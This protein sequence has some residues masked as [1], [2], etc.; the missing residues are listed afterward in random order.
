MC[1]PVRGYRE[2][3]S[4]NLNVTVESAPL[5]RSVSADIYSWAADRVLRVTP[6]LEGK[7]EGY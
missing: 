6:V 4:G 7:W 1:S 2:V 3:D 5:P